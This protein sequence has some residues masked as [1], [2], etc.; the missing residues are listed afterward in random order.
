MKRNKIHV[1]NWTI[2]FLL[3]IAGC[4]GGWD[5]DKISIPDLETG[6]FEPI[7]GLT[8]VNLSSTLTGMA[9]NEQVQQRGH[10]WSILDENPTLDSNEGLSQ[11][12]GGGDGTIESKLT[13][14]TPN[15]TYH[16]RPYVIFDNTEIYGEVK[17]FM[18]EPLNIKI[19]IRSVDQVLK[20]EKNIVQVE[21]SYDGYPDAL[22]FNSYGIAWGRSMTFNKETVDFDFLRGPIL[23]GEAI[24]EP[25]INESGIFYIHPYTIVGKDTTF[26]NSVPF[27]WQ[28]AWFKLA[29]FGGGPRENA[30]SFSIGNKGYFGLGSGGDRPFSDFWEYDS[31]TKTWSSLPDDFPGPGRIAATAFTIGDK[32]YVG[33]GIDGNDKPL[34]DFYEF[35]P[36]NNSWTAISPFPDFIYNATSFVIENTAYVG[37]GES[38]TNY[39]GDFYSWNVSTG[40]T[41]VQPPFVGGARASAAGFA[42]NNTGY[43]GLGIDNSGPLNDF[44]E[45]DPDTESWTTTT[46]FPFAGRFAPS[47]FVLNDIGYIMAGADFE[48]YFD[49][50]IAFDP[51][52]G[53]WNQVQAFTDQRI[54]TASFSIENVGY[55]GTG[56]TGE[57]RKE[58]FWEYLPAK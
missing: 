51:S 18:T 8:Q 36:A 14:L 52:N 19:E 29:N 31:D 54:N 38:A 27:E 6:T 25:K 3:L 21:V 7:D 41:K 44:Y 12:G 58:D 26:G 47:T 48:N 2:L 5:L 34:N 30:V 11:K 53:S 32:G 28:N 13:G 15:K 23:L 46:P 9:N 57:F 45:F 39:F 55:L 22:N 16:F 49:E 35:D 24:F 43:V 17:D 40:W 42:I 20:N 56:W 33:L 4:K 50:V 1:Y 37:L 10:V